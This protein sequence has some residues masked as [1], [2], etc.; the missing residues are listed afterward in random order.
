[1]FCEERLYVL[2]MFSHA[3]QDS[4]NLA[5]RYKASCLY[6]SLSNIGDR[7]YAYRVCRSRRH[8]LKNFWNCFL[9]C[10]YTIPYNRNDNKTCYLYLNPLQ[11]GYVFFGNET[12]RFSGPT[13]AGGNGN[14][15]MAA[16][17]ILA[18]RTS[19]TMDISM[20]KMCFC[21]GCWVKT[22]V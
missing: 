10:E 1:M 8:I 14:S 15:C 13:R 16:I 5:P 21:E 20:K 9:T 2:I 3:I 22:T 11:S 7:M 12:A 4:H 18:L 17:V 19:P 6:A